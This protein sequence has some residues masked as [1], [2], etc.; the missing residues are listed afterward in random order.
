[1]RCKSSSTWSTMWR[2]LTA[3]LRPSCR[4]RLLAITD[5][6]CI[7]ISRSGKTVRTCSQVMD[8]RDYRT[9]RYSTS[10]VSSSMREPST[11][12]QMRQQTH[13]S[14]WFLA[15]KRRSCSHIQRVTVLHRFV[16]LTFQARKVAVS[17]FGSRIQQR[18]HTW[19]SLQC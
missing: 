19:H 11:P 12:S 2:M 17:R 3:R 15:S 13:T 6:V 9:K 4:S 1:M 14:V 8:T 16:F 5:Q 10:A 18:T 7:A